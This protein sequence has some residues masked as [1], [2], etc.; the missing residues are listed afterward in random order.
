M[1]ARTSLVVGGVLLSVVFGLPEESRAQDVFLQPDRPPL[2]ENRR[3]RNGLRIVYLPQ[4]DASAVGVERGNVRIAFGYTSGLRDEADYPSGMSALAATYL[5][6]SSHARGVALATHFAGGEF[7]FSE[8]LDLVGMRIGVP[9]GVVETILGQIAL[10]FRQATVVDPDML[11]YARALA[12]E[13]ARTD[14]D[15]FKL[16]IDSEI[17]R[18]L[19]GDHPYRRRPVGQV[20]DIRHIDIADF[21]RYY[22]ENF[23]T[24]RAFVIVSEPLSDSWSE[25]FAA[26][27]ARPSTY[28]DFPGVAIRP[29]T[30]TIEFPSRPTGAVILATAVPS[31][32]FQ[33]WFTMLILD[34]VMRQVVAQDATFRFP[35]AVDPSFHW[36]EITV[37]IPR[38]A[39]DV[40]DSLLERIDD[41]QFRPASPDVLRMVKRGALELLSRRSTLEWFAAQDVWGALEDGWTTVRDLTSDGLRT[42]AREMVHQKRV[43]ALWAAAFEQPSVVVESLEDITES[44]GAEQETIGR[45]PGH[46]DIQMPAEL[47]SDDPD[48]VHVDKIA[49]GITLA[50]A[51]VHKVFVAG[52][53]ESDLPGGLSERGANGVLWSFPRAPDAA[54]FE[55]LEGVRSDRILVFAPAPDIDGE[56]IRFESWTSGQ[57]DSTPSMPAGSVATGDL[58]SLLVLKMWLDGKLIEAGWWGQVDLRIRGIE[59]SRLVIDAGPDREQQVRDWIRR[60][61]DE[62]IDESEF[63]RARTAASGYFDRIRQ[64]LQVF[65]WQRDAAGSIQPPATVSLGRLRAVARI[66]FD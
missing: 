38:Y 29:E 32:H 24:D 35:L 22:E 9:G 40:R 46:V 53:F 37:E 52:R 4:I 15:D 59:G 57:R 30:S 64:D 60:L 54:V 66:Y 2:V 50:L 65:L 39:E 56:R 33:D 43:V 41:L 23:G 47:V 44:P 61:A 5:S 27:E 19:L 8:E 31:V 55:A 48:P 14:P 45:A 28:P 51:P 13:R 17:R 3:L 20:D 6:V 12:V 16:E 36:L 58:P 49:S 25:A 34:G 26:I 42:A 10:Y 21:R 11:E 1:L 62:G 63:L 18:E 7:E